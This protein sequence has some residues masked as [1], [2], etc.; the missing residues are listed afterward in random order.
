MKRR[1][2]IAA[3]GG[4][5]ISPLATRAQQPAM[6]V[7]GF[8]SSS[9]SIPT[10]KRIASLNQGL[11]E[12]GYVAGRDFMIEPRLAEGQYDRLPALAAD[13][14]S[15]RV[16]LIV[17]LAPPAAFAAKA[18]T[19]TIPIVFVA[20]FDPVKGGLVDSFNR[21]GGN[22]TGV[23][24]M[25]SGLGAKRLELVRELFPNVAVIA[26]LTYP[27]SLDGM[28][29][30]RD[31]EVAAKAIGQQLLVLPAKSESDFSAAFA[32]IVQHGAGAVLIGSDQFFL[33][34]SEQLIA[35]ASRHRV[36]VVYPLGEAVAGG[37]LM[38]Y[39]TSAP[40]AWRL[41]GVYAGRILKG[42][43]PADLPVQA[44]TKYELVINLN[45]AKALG[46]TVPPQLLA[47]ADEVIE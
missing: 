18:A 8:L 39:G 42:A 43:K 19:T 10:T 20:S 35:L 16:N 3:L 28:E 7:I 4:A 38:S 17:T 14:V 21:P 24:F 26:L 5:A 32:S 22:V 40:D 1:S 34:K 13:L 15:R 30:L 6:P 12:A 31:L 37:A 11:S 36:P 27:N 41:A 45:T 47:R 29:E 44:P 25:T 9:S 33:E 46:L 23:T 2:F